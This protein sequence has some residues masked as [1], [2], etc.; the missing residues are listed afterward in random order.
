MTPDDFEALPAE[1]RERLQKAVAALQDQL[2]HALRASVRLRKEHADRVRTLNRST[3]QLSVDH[4][5]DEAKARYADL[6]AV[7]AY[8]DAV[9][10]SVID[11]ADAFRARE[12]GSEGS[13][14]QAG[15]LARYEANL[16]V[17]SGDGKDPAVVRITRNVLDRLGK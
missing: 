7:A 15:D 3:T 10:V 1:E 14:G 6:P 12:E 16:V 8:L 9:R 2:L 4:A 11:N 13:A 17:D 5:L